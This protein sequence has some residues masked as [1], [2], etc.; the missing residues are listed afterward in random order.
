MSEREH[1]KI[2]RGIITA[3][4][5]GKYTVASIDREGITLP[6][7]AALFEET[8]YAEGD[9]VVYFSFKDGTGRIICMMDDAD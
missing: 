9:K 1:G 5:S 8:E 4:S 2:E 6:P 7:M 3:V